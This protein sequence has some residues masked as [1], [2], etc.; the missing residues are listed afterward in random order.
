MLRVGCGHVNTSARHIFIREKERERRRKTNGGMKEPFIS[1][2]VSDSVICCSNADLSL[3]VLLGGDS[4]GNVWS[5][6]LCIPRI[7]RLARNDDQSHNTDL[8]S[9]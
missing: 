8:L 4:P 3:Y 2:L 1:V 5:L 7:V 9:M 6:S